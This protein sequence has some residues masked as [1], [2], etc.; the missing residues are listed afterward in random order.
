MMKVTKKYNDYILESKLVKL[1]FENSLNASSDFLS[2]LDLIKQNSVANIILQIFKSRLYIPDDVDQNWIDISDEDNDKI[3]FLP[4]KK[5]SGGD[6]DSNSPYLF[7]GRSTIKIGRF[8]NAILNDKNIKSRIH[9][10]SF[11]LPDIKDKDIEEFV[12]LYKATKVEDD[13]KFRLVK[14]NDI[15]HWYSYM[16]HSKD[17]GTL[18]ESCMKNSPAEF[19]DIYEVNDDVCQ[20][21]IYTDADDKL[22]GRALLWKMDESPTS[23]AK[24]FMDRAYVSNDSD[25]VKFVNYAKSQGWLYKYRMSF[26]SEESMLFYFD[27][28][29]VFGK[30]VVKLKESEFGKYPFLDTLHFLDKKGKTISNAAG[31]GDYL[32]YSTY[33]NAS[34][35]GSCRGTG[36]KC[37][38]YRCSNGYVSCREC[39]TDGQV[40]CSKCDGGGF[41]NDDITCKKCK[42]AGKLDCDECNGNGKIKCKSCK[43]CDDCVGIYK[44]AKKKVDSGNWAEFIK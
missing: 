31:I 44:S 12:N 2:R 25:I 22:L 8:A 11:Y 37:N 13:K 24:Y 38:E 16:R 19:F 39:N 35:C 3:T 21:L 9:S 4:D 7:K 30:V 26:D 18:G 33:G 42:G 36:K 27:G 15:P 32:L 6:T 5:A 28:K 23:K 43:D 41:D 10:S 20:L 1:L 29:P 17:K 40:I 14:G 34:V